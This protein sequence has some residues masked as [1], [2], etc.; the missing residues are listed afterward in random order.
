MEN[1]QLTSCLITKG[2]LLHL[3]HPENPTASTLRISIQRCTEGSRPFRKARKKKKKE[4]SISERKS[5][6]FGKKILT[7][8]KII[9]KHVMFEQME[10]KEERRERMGK[11]NI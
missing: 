3:Y 5:E 4:I 7:S 1:L 2:L 8:C 9:A 10:S 6:N 11:K